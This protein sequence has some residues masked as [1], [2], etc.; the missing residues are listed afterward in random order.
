MDVA[1]LFAA[2]RLGRVERVQFLVEERDVELNVRDMWDSTPLYYA[3]LCGHRALVE[4]LLQHGAR[5]EADTFD[6]ERALYGALT[7]D[8]R[9][10]LLQHKAVTK[11]ILRRNEYEEFLRVL[12]ESDTDGLADVALVIHE[13]RFAAHKCILA[14]RS[15]Y[16][17][18]QLARRWRDRDVI[19]NQHPLVDAS[20]FSAVL[21]YIYVGRLEIDVELVDDCL[22]LCKQF[23][24]DHLEERLRRQ[25]AEAKFFVATKMGRTRVRT[26]VIEPRAGQHEL[27]ADLAQLARHALPPADFHCLP[28]DD[29]NDGPDDEDEWRHLADVVFVVEGQ[30]FRCHK[31]FFCSRSEFFKALINDHFHESAADH[32]GI[33]VI[34]LHD[35]SAAAFTA[36]VFYMYQDSAEIGADIVT[37]LLFTAEMYLL[38]GLKKQCAGVMAD[39]LD[40]GNVVGVLRV[41]RQLQLPRLQAACVEFIAK[42]IETLIRSAEL[43]A[44]IVED[45]QDVQERQETD[46]IDVVDDIRFY[47]TSNVQTT[48]QMADAR[49]RLALIDG[50]LEQLGLDA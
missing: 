2:C 46:T 47:V 33:P 16:F 37:E 4:Y 29:D 42:N 14:A 3:C 31:A 44:L 30:H 19:R 38:P 8:I 35:I 32:T 49:D 41:A 50:L 26:L 18:R 36:V 28:F 27:H 1:E 39:H 11:H 12:L 43:Q 15:P 10:L 25:K 20:A 17:R 45:A 34:T 13:E 40:C 22:R 5:C 23:G 6:G 21:R 48:S 7:E 9:R 24:L